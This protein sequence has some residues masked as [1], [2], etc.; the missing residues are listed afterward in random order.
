MTTILLVRHCSVPALGRYLA[1]RA[2]GEHLDVAGRAQAQ[3]LA[4]RFAGTQL[5]AVFSSPL[6]RTRETAAAL[7][8]CAPNGVQLADALLEVDFGEWTRKTF[9][10]LAS[11]PRWAPFNEHRTITRIPGGELI[12]EVQARAVGFVQCIA[13]EFPDGRVALVSHG[14]VIRSTICYYLGLPLDSMQRFHIA[15]GSVSVLRLGEAGATL[16]SMN[17]VDFDPC[18]L[19]APE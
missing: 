9:A 11:D 5:D 6:E 12:F 15:P 13:D 1:G 10:E 3:R 16:Q 2:P 14:D 17:V 7:A 4:E 19:D 18:S 8:Q